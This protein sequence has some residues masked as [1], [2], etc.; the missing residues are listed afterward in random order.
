MAITEVRRAFSIKAPEMLNLPYQATREG[1]QSEFWIK[2]CNESA[3][4]R[5][6]FAQAARTT[7]CKF[8]ILP[9]GRSQLAA[10][11]PVLWQLRTLVFA[12]GMQNAASNPDTA[13][14]DAD[15]LLRHARQ[16]F[17]GPSTEAIALGYV[18][19]A[20]ALTVIDT[21]FG[22]TSRDADASQRL[23]KSLED[24]RKIRLTE[25]Q[26]ADVTFEETMRRLKVIPG[27]IHNKKSRLR[28]IYRLNKILLL[29]RDPPR[30]SLDYKW[31]TPKVAAATW[32]RELIKIKRPVPADDGLRKAY[33]QSL[34]LPAIAGLEGL[35]N[36][37]AMGQ[38][39]LEDL[40][41]KLPR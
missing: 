23:R 28:V 9:S 4:A 32:S 14:L 5:S 37:H 30:A 24:H 22:A 19:E 25:Q 17:A 41:E 29:V 20:N 15:T 16:L 34:K 3:V 7:R 33:D 10:M 27:I 6:L 38:K 11:S 21:T 2:K 26:I 13:L 35:L 12:H 18:A 40:L 36:R 8:G 39:L 31:R 1:Y